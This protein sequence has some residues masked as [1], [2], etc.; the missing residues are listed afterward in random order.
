MQPLTLGKCI[1]FGLL[2]SR[3][4]MVSARRSSPNISALIRQYV[5]RFLFTGPLTDGSAIAVHCIT[6]SCYLASFLQ[7]SAVRKQRYVPHLSACTQLRLS[8]VQLPSLP[9][10]VSPLIPSALAVDPHVRIQCHHNH[11]LNLLQLPH[12]WATKG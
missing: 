5:H 10:K 4:W 6:L 12:D 7:S 1:S 2:I 11:V 9:G 3:V 8:L